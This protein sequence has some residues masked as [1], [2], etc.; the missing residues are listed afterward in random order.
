MGY[1]AI[2]GGTLTM[3]GSSPLILLND[4][5]IFANPQ[6]PPH[7]SQLETFSLFAVTPIGVVLLLVGGC[8][9]YFFGKYVLPVGTVKSLE[10]GC[11]CE[12][13][14]RCLRNYRSSL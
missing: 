14:A 13:C 11:C 12:L 10:N 9:F 5:I 1:C 4:L 3:V 6:L 8:Y 7:V 2:L